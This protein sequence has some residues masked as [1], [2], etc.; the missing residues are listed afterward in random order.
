MGSHNKYIPTISDPR[1][2]EKNCFPNYL[3]LSAFSVFM[4]EELFSLKSGQSS[5]A[6]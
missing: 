2:V 1:T 4:A 3:H 5:V 6:L